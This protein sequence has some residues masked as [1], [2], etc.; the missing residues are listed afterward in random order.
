MKIAVGL[1]E[2][3]GLPTLLGSDA[4]QLWSEVAEAYPAG[5]DHTEVARWLRERSEGSTVMAE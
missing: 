3:L 4:V 2:E 5:A 1:S